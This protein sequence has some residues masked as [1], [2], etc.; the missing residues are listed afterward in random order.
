MEQLS[1]AARQ[2]G[3][4]VGIYRR[5][6]EYKGGQMHRQRLWHFNSKCEGYPPR[7]FIARRDRPSDD[8]LCGRCDR[9]SSP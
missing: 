9:A 1:F 2:P 7:N 4:H 8:E 3:A 5:G 6:M